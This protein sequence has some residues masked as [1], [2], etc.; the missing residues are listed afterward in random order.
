MKVNFNIEKLDRLLNDFYKITGLTVSIWDSDINQLTYQP[1]EHSEFCR[2]IKSAPKG[3]QRC[4]ACDK[5]LC[6]KCKEAKGVVSQ[7][8]HAGLIDTAFP[9]KFEQEILGYIMFGQVVGENKS[10][11][12]FDGKEIC[13]ELKLDFEALNAAYKKLSVNDTHTINSAAN[14]L[15][16]ATRYIWLSDLLKIDRS[17]IGADIDKYISENLSSEM[18]IPELCEKFNISKSKL[19]SLSEK[20]FGM[21]IGAYITK[22][23]IDEAKHLLIATDKPIYEISGLVG[24]PDYNYFTKVFKKRTG[25]APHKYRKST[26]SS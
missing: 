3:A 1:R 23:R 7:K 16:A 10:S 11:F 6:E 20:N 19:Y 22:K 8:C 18:S 12:E 14:I 15:I 24:I 2:I 4:T 21:T 5:E 17:T 9:I 25:S 26:F 13:E